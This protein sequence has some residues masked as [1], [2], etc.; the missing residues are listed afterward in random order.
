[1]FYWHCLEIKLVPSYATKSGVPLRIHQPLGAGLMLYDRI[2]LEELRLKTTSTSIYLTNGVLAGE[3]CA[4]WT[5]DLIPVWSRPRQMPSK[6]HD[7]ALLYQKNEALFSN[8]YQSVIP[9]LLATREYNRDCM[10]IRFML[11]LVLDYAFYF[12]GKALGVHWESRK[13][14]IIVTEDPEKIKSARQ[15]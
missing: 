10:Y 7:L 12:R 14:W 4:I 9:W 8:H 2:V 13:K 5:K 1:M 15:N 3:L 11:R 6:S